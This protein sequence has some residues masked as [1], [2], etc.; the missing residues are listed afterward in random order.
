LVQ[1]MFQTKLQHP[2]N[3]IYFITPFEEKI[4]S[5][6]K[7][8]LYVVELSGITVDMSEIHFVTPLEYLNQLRLKNNLL[9]NDSFLIDEKLQKKHTPIADTIF[10]DD[11]HLLDDFFIDF[12]IEQKKK[13]L[14]CV[15]LLKP[16]ETFPLRQ[17]Y[18]APF[19]IIQANDARYLHIL[20]T[21]LEKDRDNIFIFYQN[22]T[23]EALQEEI[24]GFCGI[25]A[26]VVDKETPNKEQIKVALVQY[27]P[28]FSY[29]PNY[30]I[31]LETKTIPSHLEKHYGTLAQE[32]NYFLK[33]NI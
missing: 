8:L 18:N 3:A 22:A 6:E 19:E 9:P 5:L 28:Y 2:K 29:Y 21:L 33:G 20:Y 12:L 7:D 32:K 4:A 13:N 16:I 27:D 10:C 30:A 26:V 1:K 23:A 17:E 31:F 25:D 15:N 24:K 14:Y 11:T